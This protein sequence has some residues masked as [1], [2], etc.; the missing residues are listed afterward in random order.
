MEGKSTSQAEIEGGLVN[1][2]KVF[3]HSGSDQKLASFSEL[4]TANKHLTSQV[5]QATYGGNKYE[6]DKVQVHREPHSSSGCGGVSI[7]VCLLRGQRNRLPGPLA[8]RFLPDSQIPDATLPGLYPEAFM[9]PAATGEGPHSM[10]W[11]PRS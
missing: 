7:Y 3:S 5:L 2:L 1:F 11:Q 9:A 4:P 10:A 8:S 6:H